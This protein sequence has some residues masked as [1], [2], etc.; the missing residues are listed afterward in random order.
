[1]NGFMYEAF[2][3]SCVLLDKKRIPD[4][5]GGFTE[6]W[7]DSVNF[8]AAITFDTSMEARIGAK[9]GVTSR[10]TVTVQRGLKLEFH[11]VFRR[12]S[13]GK[14]FRVTSDGDDKVTPPMAS[15]S[16]S[17]VTAEEWKI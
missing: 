15:F 5:E 13:D 1:M 9:Q 10:Y 8:E 7:T 6:Q 12:L 14:I 16:F 11:D 3:E 2:N 17:Q 4:G